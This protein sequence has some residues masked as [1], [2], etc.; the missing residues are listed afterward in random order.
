MPRELRP[1]DIGLTEELFDYT[2]SSTPTD[3]VSNLA[4]KKQEKLNSLGDNLLQKQKDA[5]VVF[6]QDGYE[7]RSGNKVLNELSDADAQGM[8]GQQYAEQGLYRDEQGTTKR[9]ADDAEYEG[10]TAW[11]Y[12][13]G[14][15]DPESEA[16]KL[17]I[18]R[19]EEAKD[20]Y[21]A[22]KHPSYKYGEQTADPSRVDGKMELLFPEEVATTL[23]ALQHGR[24]E[25]LAN[26]QWRKKT[27]G[28]YDSAGYLDFG[29]GSS[30]VYTS[31][32][33][34]WGDS[35]D[36]VQRSPEEL[37]EGYNAVEDSIYGT[38]DL[39]G[40]D[41]PQTTTEDPLGSLRSAMLARESSGN[42]KA[43]NDIGYV[44]GYQFGASA[45][46]D[47][48]YVQKGASKKGNK[49]LAVDVWTGKDGVNSL[50]DFLGSKEV[51]DKAFDEYAQTNL[52]RLIKNG[53]IT[54]VMSDGDVAGFLASAHLLGSG[55]AANLDEMDANNTTGRE[56][57]E[58]G[59]GAV[60]GGVVVET[61]GAEDEVAQR[62]EDRLTNLIDAA[63]YG[64]GRKAAGVSD[65][66]LDGMTRVTKDGVKL[67]TDKTE[68]ELNSNLQSNIKGTFLEGTF[69]DKGDFVGLDDYKTAVEYGY[70]DRH[71][72]AVLNKVGEAY[73]D[74]DWLRLAG[75]IASGV[76][77]AGPEFLLESSGELVIVALGPL[78][79]A[80]NTGDYSNQIMEE[81][82]KNID[83]DEL[84]YN[85]RA[86]AI[87]G[88]T[89]M[90][91]LNKAGVDELVGN[92]SMVKNALKALKLYGTD[93]Q[94]K[95]V[96]KRIVSTATKAATVT[97][98]KGLYE[99]MEE[100][101]QEAVSIVAEKIGTKEADKI[102]SDASGQ[103]LVEGFAGGFA[104]G[105]TA[106][107]S[108][109]AVET[110]K[111][112]K[113][114]KKKVKPV[115]DSVETPAVTVDSF[116]QR[117]AVLHGDIVK[118]NINSDNVS[119]YVDELEF[120]RTNRATLEGLTDNQRKNVGKLEKLA[121]DKIR[122]V[123]EDNP[124]LTQVNEYEAERLLHTVL[125]SSPI[126]EQLLDTL[127]SFATKNKISKERFDKI[128]KSYESVEEEATIGDRGVVTGEANLQAMIA[129]GDIDTKKFTDEFNRLDK[130]R[131]ATDKSIR[132][133]EA[134]LAEANLEV[135]KLNKQVA[136]TNKKTK[137]IPT[138]YMKID[139]KP[140]TLD[141]AFEDGKW[142]VKD[143][144]L[145]SILESKVNRR[146]ELGRILSEVSSKSGGIVDSPATGSKLIIPQDAYK[147]NVVTS[148][149]QDESY[150]SKRSAN[151]L[152][153][154]GRSGD[155]TKVVLGKSSTPKWKQGS[156]YRRI[157]EMLINIGDY[158]KGDVVLFNN[159]NKTGAKD[160]AGKE[161]KKAL[162]AEA[163]VVLDRDTYE[164][165]KFDKDSLTR[166]KRFMKKHGYGEVEGRGYFVKR[167]D[168]TAP[169]IDA[170]K[171]A[172][173][174]IQ[175][176]KANIT[177][178][179][180]S[181]IAALAEHRVENDDASM[182]KY[183]DYVDR[184]LGLGVDDAEKRIKSELDKQI[185]HY[186]DI[187]L[188]VVNGD[189]NAVDELGDMD[190]NVE[191]LGI[192]ALERYEQS[193]AKVL[194]L[195]ARW[196]QLTEEERLRGKSLT[197]E[198]AKLAEDV[199]KPMKLVK[200]ILEKD[201]ASVDKAD[202]WEEVY[203][204]RKKEGK[205]WVATGTKEK[206][207]TTK[208]TD[209]EIA[210]F[211]KR[212]GTGT[213]IPL[214]IRKVTIDL[215]KLVKVSKT[216]VL[217]SVP[218]NNLTDKLKEQ[219]STFVKSVG[220]AIAT[221]KGTQNE[222][223]ELY[224]SP[225]RGL[226][227]DAEGKVNEQVSMA[228][229]LAVGDLLTTDMYKLLKRNK[230]DEDVARLFNVEAS[231]VSKEM[232][233]IAKEHG[234]LRKT[235]ASTLGKATLSKLGITA[236]RE[237]VGSA[238]YEALVA[239]LGNIAI[240][241]AIKQ[242][243]LEET[244]TKSD[245][246]AGLMEAGEK[247]FTEAQTLFV[248]VPT[249]KRTKEGTKYK[250]SAPSASVEKA[251]EQ[252]EIAASVMPDNKTSEVWPQL[253]ALDKGTV[254][255]Q[256][257]T[258][259]NDVVQGEIPEDAKDTLRNMM[260]TEYTFDTDR[261]TAFLET[262]EENK[263]AVKEILGFI[264]IGSSK[265]E[266]LPLRDKEIQES[267]NNEVE[268]SIDVLREMAE[269]LGEGEHGI[270]FKHYYTGNG[271]FMLD[272]NTINPQ[273][274][275]L[276]RFLIQ[277]KAHKSKYTVSKNRQ[278]FKED[279]KDV[280]FLV[281]E[282]LAQAMGMGIDKESTQ[283]KVLFGNALLTLDAGQREVLKQ[284]VISNGEA[285]FI[286]DGKTW[287]VEAEH[288]SHTLQA[289]D[290]LEQVDKGVVISSITA[291]Y[292]SLTSGYNNKLQQFPVLGD[293]A[294]ELAKVG[295]IVPEYMTTNAGQEFK[296]ELGK[297]M[298]D[299]F[300]AG[301]D[302]GFLDSYQTLAKTVV[303]K[304]RVKTSD[305]KTMFKGKNATRQIQDFNN[306]HKVLPGG[307]QLISDK[308]EV[309]IDKAMRNLFKNPFMI[310]NYS[311][312]VSTIVKNLSTD[313]VT[314]VFTSIAKMDIAEE[315]K[316]GTELYKAAEYLVTRTKSNSV[317]HLQ[318]RIREEPMSSIQIGEGK[319][320]KPAV[321]VLSKMVE[322]SYGKT[323]TEVFDEKFGKFLE[324]Q[325]ITNDSFKVMFRLFNVQRNKALK[326]RGKKGTITAQDHKEVLAELWDSFPYIVGPLTGAKSKKDVISILSVGTST[327]TS[328]E[329][330][331]R[332]P[333]TQLA[334]A[335]E[336]GWWQTKKVNPLIKGLDEA[337]SAG[338]VLPFHY[339][340]GAELGGML[341]AFVEHV[342]KDLAGVIPIH[343]AV[344]SKLGLSDRVAWEYNKKVYETNK[345]YSIMDSLAKML[346]RG[347]EVL[348]K[349]ED[350]DV[351]DMSTRKLDSLGEE[352]NGG[353][354]ETF[355]RV[356]E[357]L[358]LLQE[359]TSAARE[360][361]YKVLDEAYYAN[362][363][364]TPA[365]VYRS[366][367]EAPSIAYVDKLEG[368]YKPAEEVRVVTEKDGAKE[369]E[370]GIMDAKVDTT[371]SL[372][373]DEK[374]EDTKKASK[375]L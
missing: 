80:L 263:T 209:T 191:V 250:V 206:V 375:C 338:S 341:N 307:N 330:S 171:K 319:Y 357:K 200:D 105:T 352:W 137:R 30:E 63:Q 177:K 140:Y 326:E 246:I 135:D 359:E 257:A 372:D 254:E 318:E 190:S 36:D 18:S 228:M 160:G 316:E 334:G 89:A 6:E 78:G 157:N 299:V 53:T 149:K 69:N 320:V 15:K 180:N 45:L 48:G 276:H 108:R 29:G 114:P 128:I 42:Y 238:E 159:I 223:Y 183:Q 68:E 104:G 282:A 100:V 249:V 287:E 270:Y 306:L 125:G 56:Y 120:I 328:I 243:L 49:V 101:A 9:V 231:E 116:K 98:G 310:F 152:K 226:V 87:A 155:V 304:L 193:N 121:A 197:K 308:A 212:E 57:F 4:I 349:L 139:G 34:L 124:E 25:A 74:K 340:D 168:D 214:A 331:R 3:K 314:D 8:V 221:K 161:L 194:A 64:I 24:K 95:S 142:T 202:V 153:D 156:D 31:K 52:N 134:G 127:G 91:Y 75:E 321:E 151:I 47:L 260:D 207:R 296:P 26:R 348:S 72:K 112:V 129:G 5:G 122:K 203:Q 261:V 205:A 19:E 280:S 141:V 327:P 111:V 162:D 1:E 172:K 92:T 10:N 189:I 37:R 187:M 79:L 356:K 368:M 294:G 335:T 267:I 11:L 329:E 96:A 58:L 148:R 234:Q 302:A 298:N 229:Y 67:F 126:D 97:G 230:T 247:R 235:V 13:Y 332:S 62:P 86:I 28:S 211:S 60:E 84:S 16:Y 50:A 167:D 118:D 292:D 176:E 54:D 337:R 213:L 251:V 363:I 361:M 188:K 217:N 173:Q 44:G 35:R 85:D 136:L 170:A 322:N 285:A 272:S 220:K 290:F 366:G 259:R 32:E 39:E 274:N 256:L 325:D 233:D 192:E 150:L 41:L 339:I 77:T 278:V 81:R 208:P 169:L 265:Y 262:Y 303:E 17:G 245:V 166:F 165:G 370:S 367:E 119:E 215:D 195:L 115:Q 345:N 88:G 323:V 147:K 239:D 2:T 43:I 99:G 182:V 286:A 102:L 21:D 255:E 277:P 355:G 216:T 225:A 242:G 201:G 241:S 305:M 284:E 174:K 315:K 354:K 289:F 65:A 365:S 269:K 196:K 288:L 343:D 146:K 38:E 374:V 300:A 145:K 20:R 7:Y 281:R 358:D 94:V 27:D 113:L 175:T 336:K 144:H 350:R 273:T 244:S 293:M 181:G 110:I 33:G 346:K 103:R 93:E 271:R 360:V 154:L 344:M 71:T 123:L 117:A 266:K 347:E 369:P 186:V 12:G 199:T 252:Y 132:E 227:L 14:S 219:G 107:T 184:L 313:I 106:N 351:K 185:K 40:K 164:K 295:I 311:A 232:K 198:I 283:D 90:S 46:E 218:V 353:F 279:G 236:K 23:E 362:M 224:N 138:G 312:K 317:A 268:R 333:Q 222:A 309:E 130:F 83:G 210:E 264:E 70:D 158:N 237:D 364:G 258:I 131:V 204:V 373:A 297:G 163:V 275:K 291:E 253:G 51:Q 179:I 73:K 109:A 371:K 22:S 324:I 178:F 143:A 248:N 301:K 61:A 240:E 76:V 55:N 133:L 82:L 66:I 342:G 59:K